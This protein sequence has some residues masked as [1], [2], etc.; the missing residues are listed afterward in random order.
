MNDLNITICVNVSY[1]IKFE[2]YSD[3]INFS[4]WFKIIIEVRKKIPSIVFRDKV[5]R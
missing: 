4:F 1:F 2:A 3:L 5:V